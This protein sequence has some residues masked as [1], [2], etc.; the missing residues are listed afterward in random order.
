M[1]K[2]QHDGVC[3][4]NRV[5]TQDTDLQT[6]LV[7]V[8]WPTPPHCTP[9]PTL[10]PMLP[11]ILGR[12]RPPTFYVYR[13]SSTLPFYS[14]AS[15]SLPLLTHTLFFKLFTNLYYKSIFWILLWFLWGRGALFG[16]DSPAR[17]AVLR[18]RQKGKH[19][20]DVQS[21]ETGAVSFHPP[22]P[23]KTQSECGDAGISSDNPISA[24]TT[25]QQH[26]IAEQNF[27][28]FPHRF[29][30]SLTMSDTSIKGTK[31]EHVTEAS[32][33]WNVFGGSRL[34]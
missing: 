20:M 4:P 21:A 32:P 26:K 34:H 27:P 22:Q 1:W 8:E 15:S 29:P 31:S 7:A 9:H 6:G 19:G 10:H 12:A 25:L 23:R 13:V 24:L 18:P 2:Q 3:H 5:L 30:S 11:S 28:G 33:F 17:R 14:V 16:L